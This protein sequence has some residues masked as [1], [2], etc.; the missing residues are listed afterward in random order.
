MSKIS[1]RHPFPNESETRSILEEF[2]VKLLEPSGLPSPFGYRWILDIE[3]ASYPCLDEND[4]WAHFQFYTLWWYDNITTYDHITTLYVQRDAGV[5]TRLR[6]WVQ[7]G[8]WISDAPC[9][10][11][12]PDNFSLRGLD[13]WGEEYLDV[14]RE[15][16]GHPLFLSYLDISAHLSDALQM[17]DV[18]LDSEALHANLPTRPKASRRQAR[19]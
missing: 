10:V 12:I 8:A 18:A 15:K 5:R 14:L 9:N 13:A 2:G 16:R 1:S 11:K 19:L 4:L 3:G 6:D 17:L 7:Q